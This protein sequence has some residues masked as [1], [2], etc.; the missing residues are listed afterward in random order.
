[1]VTLA[2][3]LVTLD[4][5]TPF[6]KVSNAWNFISQIFE[7]NFKRA[8]PPPPPSP[9]PFSYILRVVAVQVKSW[10]LKIFQDNIF[11]SGNSI[12]SHCRT[13]MSVGVESDCFPP[14]SCTSLV[15]LCK[16]SASLLVQA[17]SVHF[18]TSANIYT[19]VLV[20]GD[21]RLSFNISVA[22]IHRAR[23]LFFSG[24]KYFN[25]FGWN[26]NP[27]KEAFSWI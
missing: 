23:G 25:V 2:Y 12:S 27:L 4:H 7:A 24:K 15:S 20:S 8:A 19:H 5:G 9:F 22:E 3:R 10:S 26:H 16:L 17:L 1:L 14:F 13:E 6:L 11:T 21:C 18:I